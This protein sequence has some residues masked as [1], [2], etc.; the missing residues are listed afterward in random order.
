MATTSDG[1]LP[2]HHARGDS[3]VSSDWGDDDDWTPGPS[4]TSSNQPLASNKP[5][6]S[7][8][9]G[10]AGVASSDGGV[11]GARGHAGGRPMQAFGSRKPPSARA[12]AKRYA[13][14]CAAAAVIGV[15]AY[16]AAGA[17]GFFGGGDRDGGDDDAGEEWLQS[18]VS[19]STSARFDSTA[20]NAAADADADAAYDQGSHSNAAGHVPLPE[21]PPMET[22]PIEASTTSASAA[23]EDLPPIDPIADSNAMKTKV[24]SIHW[25]PYDRV[26][27]V[28]ADP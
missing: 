22:P 17:G 15:V 3:V 19:S 2:S 10:G 12:R 23:E 27:V 13:K 21:T 25:F 28:N 6:A 18:A 8:P 9:L 4:T 16:Y 20:A 7:S 1:P 24:R 11:L 26:G 14:L 5:R